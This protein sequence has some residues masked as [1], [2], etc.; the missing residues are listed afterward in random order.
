LEALKNHKQI[1]L[2]AVCG[3]MDKPVGRG[4]KIKSPATIEFAKDNHVNVF[5]S[6]S[7][8]K[9]EDFISFCD[10]E[11]PD[12]FIVLAFSHFLSQKILDIPSLGCF[13]VHTSILPKYRGSSPIHYALLNGDKSTGVSIQKMVKK[14][15]A[16]DIGYFVNQEIQENDDYL[17]LSNKLSFLSG[18]AITSFIN[19]LKEKKVAFNPQ[20]EENVSFASLIKKEDGLVNFNETASEIINK[21]R[22]FSIWPGTFFS[23]NG[24]IY[25]FKNIEAVKEISLAPGE[26]K[27]AKKE[28]FI[29][30]ADCVIN[31]KQIQPRGKPMMDAQGF[32]NG[33]SFGSNKVDL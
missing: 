19:Q 31:I 26:I 13:N 33:Y 7:I 3:S 5:Q 30:C 28:I 20:N 6:N 11:K 15:D 27:I 18:K 29:G 24:K 2:I 21:T 32:I 23:V 25:K 1:E 17:S 10:K 9:D 12:L 8:N 16:G 14:M 4:K 22:A